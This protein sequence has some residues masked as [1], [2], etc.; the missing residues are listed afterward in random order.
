MVA[1]GGETRCDRSATGAGVNAAK[2]GAAPT[3]VGTP[4]ANER[5]A[6][7]LA[8]ALVG[9]R[10]VEADGGLTGWF[11]TGA[12]TGTPPMLGRLTPP[13]DADV[14]GNGGAPGKLNVLDGSEVTGT[15]GVVGEDGSPVAAA[16]EDQ[17]GAPEGADGACGT[18]GAAG[19]DGP[20]NVG[21]PGTAGA[22]VATPGKLPSAA[23]AALGSARCANCPAST[24]PCGV[25]VAP[26]SSL[27][28]REAI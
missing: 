5:T 23:L 24:G 16:G 26:G 19:N 28:S 11:G 2:P 20:G 22:A 6:S 21:A 15:A 1:G 27:Y 3:C 10:R 25:D 8:G 14:L 17:D 9:G 12:A 18:D 4:A 13:G 7:G